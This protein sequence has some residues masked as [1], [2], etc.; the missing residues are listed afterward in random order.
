MKFVLLAGIGGFFGSSLRALISIGL[1]P[2]FFG[3]FPLATWTVNCTGSFLMGLLLAAGKPF[4][5]PEM[6][7][8]LGGGLLGGFTTY[9]AF[10][11]ESLLL[12]Q[13]QS[14]LYCS[15]YILATLMGGLITSILG[16]S[17]GRIFLPS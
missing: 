11:G 7:Q 8:L 12:I 14:L 4:L 17:L 15:L 1:S 6:Y 3:R 13:N 16:F 9:S 5:S 2:Y 10:A